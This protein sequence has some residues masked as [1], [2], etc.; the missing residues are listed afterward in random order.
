M[1]AVDNEMSDDGNTCENEDRSVVNGESYASR[2]A[3]TISF[4]K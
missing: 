4:G 2:A 1:N 3:C